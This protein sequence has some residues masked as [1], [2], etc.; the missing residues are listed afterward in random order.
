LGKD[1]VY[2]DAGYWR[3]EF[4]SDNIHECLNTDACL[5]YDGTDLDH[6]YMC[7]K[8][9][10]SNLCHTCIKVEGTQ[11][12]RTG[13]NACGICP[14]A[15]LNGFRL[16]GLLILLVIFIVVIIWSNIRTQ[17]DSQS[18]I[19]IR[20]LTNYFQIITSAASFNL[21]FPASLDGFFEGVKTVGE[22]AKIFLSVDC[23]IQDFPMVD[24]TGTTE[25][26]KAFMTGLSPFIFVMIVILTWL[27]IRV[28]KRYSFM[29]LKN[30]IIISVCIVI[31]LLHPSITG[32]SLGLFN[33]Y[34]VDSGQF[35]LFK[36]LSVRCWQGDHP[37][38]AFGLGIPMLFGWVVGLPVSA[39]FIIRYYR[40][41]LD[42]EMVV[43]RY[44]IL[45]QGYNRE[46]YYWEFVN[47][48]RKVSIVMINTFL[49]IYPPIYKTFVATLTLAIILRQQ[50]QIQPYKVKVNNECE[51]RES[52]ASIVTLF[53]GMFFI[54]EDLPGII[55]IV[56]VLV[57]FACNL[58]FYSLWIHLFFK[59]SRF[60]FV[61]LI[62]LFFGKIS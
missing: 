3:S 12:Q 58:W 53:G 59:N 15:V 1:I 23:F 29:D 26:L 22:S 49:G 44:K 61:R 50:E 18:A 45:F 21:T 10:S 28:F 56:L 16:F 51:F 20:I 9:Y 6:P 42:E 25:Y 43:M 38:Y 5:E 48:F 62:A 46:A 37:G 8:G 57:I 54:L 35:W 4:S 40:N 2:V 30:R 7:E 14:D 39:F 34:E 27:C 17:K 32:M 36:D 47:V 24:N 60:Q 33:C 41:R 11:Y 19:L 52:T 31:F 55:R 13:D